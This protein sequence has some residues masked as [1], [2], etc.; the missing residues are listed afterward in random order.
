MVLHYTFRQRF[1]GIYDIIHRVT[2]H[3]LVTE[4][5]WRHGHV[6][7]FSLR[8]CRRNRQ[9]CFSLAYAQ[10]TAVTKART[11]KEKAAGP[12]AAFSCAFG[13][14][15]CMNIQTF[16]TLRAFTI[17]YSKDNFKYMSENALLCNQK[18]WL[19]TNIFICS[20]H[21][22]RIRQ[23]ADLRHRFLLS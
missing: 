8:H 14:L 10:L 22:Y 12:S 11:Q 20:M 2:A 1:R 5:R 18:G 21:W 4:R 7:L 9:L 6:H 16:C 17:A 19:P 15:Y 13:L 3:I 23:S